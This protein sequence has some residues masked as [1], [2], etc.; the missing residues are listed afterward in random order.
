MQPSTSPLMQVGQNYITDKRET[1]VNLPNGT[2]TTARW[3]QFKIPVSQPTNT[4]GSISDFRSIRF[5]RMFMTGFSEPITVRFGALDLV[6]GEWR[7]YV[8]SFQQADADPDDDDT[9]FDVLSVNIQENASRLPIPYVLPPD[10]VREQTNAN[11]QVINQNEQSLSLRVSGQGLEVGDARAV[12]K[13][14]NVDM[15]QFNKLKMFLHAEALPAPTDP[16]PLQDN[17][18]VGF[19]RFGNG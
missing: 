11:N 9:N 4:I 19:I 16:T 8:N 14:V 17:Q 3:Y 7:R 18:M 2:S 5:M 12:F 6:R 15:R 10:V 13:N 1:V